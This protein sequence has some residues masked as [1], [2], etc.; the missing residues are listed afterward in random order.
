VIGNKWVKVNFDEITED[1]E[2]GLTDKLRQFGV[3]GE[4]FETWVPDSDPVKS[5]VSLV[6]SAENADFPVDLLVSVSKATLSETSIAV[7]QSELSGR[8]QLRVTKEGDRVNIYMANV[9]RKSDT[10]LTLLKTWQSSFRS[11]GNSPVGRG[12]QDGAISESVNETINQ[13]LSLKAGLQVRHSMYDLV[14]TP[15]YSHQGFLCCSEKSCIVRSEASGSFLEF[16]IDLAAHLVKKARFGGNFVPDFGALLNRFCL[17]AELRPIQDV[18]DYG[19]ARLEYDIRGTATPPVRGIVFPEAVDHRFT[20]LQN[21]VRDALTKYREAT[22]Y[23]NT[24]NTFDQPPKKEWI[25]LSDSQKRLRCEEVLKSEIVK[26]GFKPN[27]ISVLDVEHSVRVLVRFSGSL[28]KPR[29]NKQSMLIQLE[30][31]IIQLEP[32]L[33]IFLEPFQDQSVLRRL[34]REN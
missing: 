27:D 21:L 19:V 14:D 33:E 13:T 30:K 23:T 9:C 10:R 22:G 26:L 8:W 3:E 5:I 11:T 31:L 6:D 34:G 4:L 16:E 29:V 25:A 20:R 28:A 12:G 32:R 24:D 18:S 15:P 2:I 17:L 1:Y 7:L